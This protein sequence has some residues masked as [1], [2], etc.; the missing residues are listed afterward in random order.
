MI[1]TNLN[2]KKIFLSLIFILCSITTVLSQQKSKITIGQRADGSDI[3]IDAIHFNKSIKGFHSS[4]DFKYVGLEFSNIIDGSWNTNGQFG[5]YDITNN[6]LLWKHPIDFS[7]S[8]DILTDNGAVITEGSHKS[9][10]NMQTGEKL[11]KVS[12][13]TGMIVHNDTSDILL[14]FKSLGNGTYCGWNMK[15][16]TEL[17]NTKV[18]HTKSYAG[19]TKISNDKYLILG[20]KLYMVNPSFGLTNTYDIQAGTTDIASGLISDITG[21]EDLTVGVVGNEIYSMPFM[22]NANAITGLNSN[23]CI[24]D[25]CIYFADSNKLMC[26]NTSLQPIWEYSFQKNTAAHSMITLSEDKINILNMGHGLRN[27]GN[28]VKKGIPFIASFN[29]KTG[30]MINMKDLSATG[31]IIDDAVVYK[32]RYFLMNKKGISSTM[33]TDTCALRPAWNTKL[34][35][36]PMGLLNDTVYAYNQST[37]N[38]AIISH[39]DYNSPVLSNNTNIYIVD[40]D[41]N[42]NGHYLIYS[43]YK[44]VANTNEYELV[45]NGIDNWIIRKSGIP[46]VHINKMILACE[47]KENNL[48]ILTADNYLCVFDIDEI[49]K[50]Q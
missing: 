22:T 35:G 50:E 12:C 45:S 42:I 36:T 6:K 7:Y 8:K 9:F 46:V 48:I 13:L 14:G 44:S 47:A 20:D 38:F 26:L 2:M 21:S 40:K 37:G 32:D 34:Y 29:S 49:L 23:L 17:W 15:D 39:D 31:S 3:E 33:P 25:S 27:N 24:K 10:Y 30:K 18:Y 16:G 19:C 43:L 28:K 5:V 4:P 11:W 41:I 1:R